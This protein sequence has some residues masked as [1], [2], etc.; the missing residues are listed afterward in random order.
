MCPSA[1]ISNPR[2]MDWYWSTALKNQGAQQEM[3]DGEQAL[4]LI[5]AFSQISGDNRFSQQ[6]ERYCELSMCGI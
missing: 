4:P 1:G 2:A 6:H 3:S 5:S